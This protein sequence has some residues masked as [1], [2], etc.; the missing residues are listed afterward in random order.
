M[1]HGNANQS[2]QIWKL[3]DDILQIS[4]QRVDK[5]KKKDNYTF[6]STVMKK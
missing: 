4:V 1:D 6:I 5:I 2:H 3:Y